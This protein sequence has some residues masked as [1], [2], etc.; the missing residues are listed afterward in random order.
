MLQV[1]RDL[2]QDAFLFPGHLTFQ[3]HRGRKIRPAGSSW[4]LWGYHLLNQQLHPVGVLLKTLHI[5][6]PTQLFVVEPVKKSVV[7]INTFLPCLVLVVLQRTCWGLASFLGPCPASHHLQYEKV[8]EGLVHLI[9]WL[10]CN[11]QIAKHIITKGN[12]SCVV[13]STTLMLLLIAHT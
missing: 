6:Q 3:E 9:M 4:V 10:L 5:P 12:V 7:I 2:M 8:G 13:Q 1:C 11:Q